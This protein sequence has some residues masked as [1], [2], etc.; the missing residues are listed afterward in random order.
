MPI[1]SKVLQTAT[2][3]QKSLIDQTFV[4]VSVP[5]SDFVIFK[6]FRLEPAPSGA[7]TL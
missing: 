6:I 2:N 3:L 7:L 4:V 1:P 5:D